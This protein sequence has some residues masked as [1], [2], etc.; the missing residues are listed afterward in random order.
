[1][2]SKVLSGAATAALILSFG[3]VAAKADIYQLTVVDGVNTATFDV[4]ENPTPNLD[5]S[6]LFQLNN[7]AVNIVS[8]GYDRS[9]T[10][11]I[12]FYTANGNTEFIADSGSWFADTLGIANSGAYFSGTTADP[13]FKLGTYGITG[14]SLTITD[15]SAAVPEPSTWAMMILGFVGLGFMAYRKKG[16]LR[17][18]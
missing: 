4:S 18:A 13:T 9:I 5:T 16:T 8:N 11:N 10:E 3:I 12:D 7:V 15:I 6:S 2:R 17:F 14:D 1:M